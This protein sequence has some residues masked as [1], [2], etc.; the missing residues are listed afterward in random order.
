MSQL[1]ALNVVAIY[2]MGGRMVPRA[3]DGLNALLPNRRSAAFL[4]ASHDRE[5]RDALLAISYYGFDPTEVDFPGSSCHS[6]ALPPLKS[7]SQRKTRPSH[8]FSTCRTEIGGKYTS[9]RTRL[10]GEA[11]TWFGWRPS[12]LRLALTTF[13]FA[14][15]VWALQTR[16]WTTSK[17]NPPNHRPSTSACLLC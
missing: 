1:L 16:Y 3:C 5:F 4:I 14:H 2:A 9:P 6:H 10:R 11:S 12:R 17:A 15:Q 7:V 8:D 13:S